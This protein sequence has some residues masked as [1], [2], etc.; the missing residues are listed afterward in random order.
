VLEELTRIAFADIG[1]A[2]DRHGAVIPLADLSPGIRSAI[3]EYRVRRSRNGTYTVSVRLHSKLPAL[4]A[5]GRH[6][7]IFGTRSDRATH[8]R[9]FLADP[10]PKG[11]VR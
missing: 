7:G 2:F 9:L 11:D 6:L 4:T 10:Q 5:L 8:A 1:D 3:A